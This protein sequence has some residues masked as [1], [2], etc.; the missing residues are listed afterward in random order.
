MSETLDRASAPKPETPDAASAGGAGGAE[1]ASAEAAGLEASPPRTTAPGAGTGQVVLKPRKAQPFFGRHP[2]V[3]DSAIARVEGA[4]ADGDVVD[5]VSEKQRF[6]ARGVYNSQSRLRV[7]LYSWNVGELLDVDFWRRRLKTAI[8]WRDQLGYNHPQGGARLVFSEAD[9]LSGL[10]VD[11]YGEYLTV[12]PTGRAMYERLDMLIPL[13]AELLRPKGIM[14]RGER[15]MTKAEGIEF[16]DHI[17]WGDLPRGPIFIEENGLRFGVDLAEGQKTGFYLDQRENRRAAAG[18][19]RGRK[20]LDLFC[21]SG[22]FSIAAAKLGHA[23]EIIA[24][25]SSEK[26]LALAKANADL[27][28]VTNLHL[29]AADG[30]AALDQFAGEN[31]KFGAIVLDPPK[32]ARSRGSLDEALRAYHRINRRAFDLLEP[33]G[34]LVTCSCS[35]HVSREDF[36]MMLVGVAQKTG[37]ELQILEQRGA[38]PDHPISATCLESE[39][40]KCYICRVV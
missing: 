33:G 37:R 26:A 28:G 11:R 18:Y 32:F 25:D 2:W 6:I 13:L 1:V 30:F 9:H 5:L 8:Q 36:L 20:L 10:I 29:L 7:R 22:G 17:V 12:Q 31:R 23:G 35:G 15:G 19:V 40:L 27:N 14:L 21:Y 16:A 3:L 38:A 39:Y 24:V 4:P 34:I